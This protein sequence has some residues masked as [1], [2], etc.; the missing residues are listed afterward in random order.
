MNHIFPSEKTN[1]VN[2]LIKSPDISIQYEKKDND[3]EVNHI[4]PSKKTND[5]N[6]LKKIT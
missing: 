1:D 6:D 4:V 3:N 2:D 5:G